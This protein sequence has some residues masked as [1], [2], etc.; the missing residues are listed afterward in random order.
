M[1]LPPGRP[2]MRP[3]PQNRATR[4]KNDDVPGGGSAGGGDAALRRKELEIGS[5]AL[6]RTRS[7]RDRVAH[8]VAQR[9][10][11]LRVELAAGVGADLCERFPLGSP[12][13]VR[14]LFDDR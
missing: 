4:G 3:G 5:G 12:A 2:R 10:D 6:T 13:P 11:A 8:D 7:V 1:T 14:T 9:F